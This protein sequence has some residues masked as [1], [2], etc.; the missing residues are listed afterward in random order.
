ME[1]KTNDVSLQLKRLMFAA[2]AA[3]QE[4]RAVGQIERPAMPV[5][6]GA[7]GG[8][9]K[10][11]SGASD[12]LDRKPTD[13]LL[14]VAID[15][16]T[17]SARNQ[18]SSETDTQHRNISCDRITHR[19]LLVF[20]PRPVAFVVDTHRPAHRNQH[21]N[22][23]ERAY[24]IAGEEPRVTDLRGALVQPEANASETFE[25]SMLKYMNL[26]TD[27]VLGELPFLG[28]TRLRLM[29]AL[30]IAGSSKT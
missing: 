11:R 13:F 22:A 19:Q 27:S 21:I 1:L 14:G 10:R 25:R 30:S 29:N 17:Q 5:K 4:R 3:R 24:R 26:H 28:G 18:L 7:F 12:C 20:E 9:V 15:S 2:L 8:K 6:D 23:V 16:R